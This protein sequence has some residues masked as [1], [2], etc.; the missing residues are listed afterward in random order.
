[1]TN[2]PPDLPPV[3]TVFGAGHVDPSSEQ[4]AVAAEVGETLAR[5][6]YAIAN[7]GYGGTMDAMSESAKAAGGVVIGVT[8]HLWKSPPN[9]WLDHIID[10]ADIYERVAA[11]IRISTAGYVALPGGT[12]TLQELAGVWE[13]AAK[14][15]ADGLPAVCIGE[16]WQAVADLLAREYPEAARYVTFIDGPEGL[17]A[18]FPMLPRP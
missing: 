3:V 6:G 2:F 1:V 15:H 13:Q 12:G 4:C 18:H 17:P 5:L 10:S 16:Y 14:G 11:L 7:G 8:C 9:P